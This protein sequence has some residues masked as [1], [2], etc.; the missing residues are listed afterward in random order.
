MIKKAFKDSREMVK[1]KR[2]K[3]IGVYLIYIMLV[4]MC[5][6]VYAPAAIILL[7]L[8]SAF[9]LYYYFLNL[10]EGKEQLEDIIE[11][12]K[13]WKTGLKLILATLW[14]L[15]IVFVGLILFIVPGIIWAYRYT[16]IYYILIENRDMKIEDAFK[17]SKEM[18]V[19][20]KFKFF[21]ASF[22]IM[23]VPYLLYVIGMSMM[24]SQVSVMD[25]YD[26]DYDYEYEYEFDELEDSDEL[27]LDRND[28][29]LDEEFPEYTDVNDLSFLDDM[30]VAVAPNYIILGIG[31]VLFAVGIIWLILILPRVMAVQ[32][33]YYYNLKELPIIE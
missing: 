15:L 33:A 6:S 4:L 32:I 18:M 5:T 19:G 11:F 9:G 26:H 25:A 29:D 31:A 7:A 14:Y 1:G 12:Y 27:D 20:H 21:I 2:I 22:A 10:K 17:K 28:Y 3:L 30:E 16:L 23:I 24:L 8:P 13:D